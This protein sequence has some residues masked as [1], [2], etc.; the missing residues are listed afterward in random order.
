MLPASVVHYTKLFDPDS[1]IHPIL[2]DPE[3]CG[4]VSDML[5]NQSFSV[6]IVVD[7]VILLASSCHFKP[8]KKNAKLSY[9]YVVP[10]NII[11]MASNS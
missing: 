9:D 2:D 3:K 7:L 6:E 1:P 10:E 8:Q 4:T 5:R 11:Q